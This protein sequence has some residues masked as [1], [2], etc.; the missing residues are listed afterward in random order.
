MIDS[1]T[2]AAVVFRADVATDTAPKSTSAAEAA[3]L[4]FAEAF[5]CDEFKYRAS[6]Q[7]ELKSNREM[8]RMASR[9]EQ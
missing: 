3:T 6:N 1:A 5:V 9:S 4:A 7:L 2:V 8:T